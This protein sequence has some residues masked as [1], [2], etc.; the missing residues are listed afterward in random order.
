MSVTTPSFTFTYDF[1]LAEMQAIVAG[2]MG[3]DLT[4]QHLADILQPQFA[5]PKSTLAIALQRKGLCFDQERLLNK[6]ECLEPQKLKAL[7]EAIASVL[8]V[9]PFDLFG[10]DLLPSAHVLRA[11]G[12]V[13]PT[14]KPA[15]GYV[16]IVIEGGR[17]FHEVVL[18]P[19][20][21]KLNVPGSTI[22]KLAGAA[23]IRVHELRGLVAEQPDNLL[24]ALCYWLTLKSGER[25]LRV[26]EDAAG[27]VSVAPISTADLRNDMIDGSLRK[28]V[29]PGVNAP[30][31][32]NI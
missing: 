19:E 4:R 22:D 1:S 7:Q 15:W 16:V 2:A 20:P 32:R 23:V 26:N 8:S 9:S 24:A 5:D 13:A 14:G 6:V 10:G 28:F 3:S 31:P 21:G 30:W 12:L 17:H 25:Y 27:D 29:L 18:H 11:F